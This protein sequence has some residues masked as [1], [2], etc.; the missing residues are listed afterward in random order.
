MILVDQH[1][2]HERIVYEQMKNAL[3]QN[4]LPR[5]GLLLPEIIDLS[6]ADQQLLL[7]AANTLTHLGL[8][9]EEFGPQAI[10][11]RSIPALLGA[12]ANLQSLLKDIVALLKSESDPSEL[13]ERRLFDI[14]AKMACY[15]SVR[16]GRSL[17]IAE[18]NACCARWKKPKNQVS[19]T[20][21]ARL[22]RLWTVNLWKNSSPGANFSIAYS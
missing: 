20:M 15:G 10:A 3:A 11:V 22:L 5:Q 19:A 21:A 4:N 9:V 8:E 1:A 6:A 18:M 7:G 14:C 17:N 2:A 13:L 16:A 12:D